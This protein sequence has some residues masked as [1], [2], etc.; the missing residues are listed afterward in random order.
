MRATVEFSEALIIEMKLD[1]AVS[2]R[3]FRAVNKN[4]P[5]PAIP[6]VID[7]E[8]RTDL[9]IKTPKPSPPATICLMDADLGLYCPPHDEQP[10][11]VH[12][13]TH[14]PTSFPANSQGSD[15]ISRRSRYR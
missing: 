6:F 1:D 8:Y 10:N 12:E 7:L 14:R 2:R 15:A 4:N 13:P 9:G 3:D 11:A 5:L